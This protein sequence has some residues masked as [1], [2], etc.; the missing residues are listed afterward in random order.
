MLKHFVNEW[1]A[2]RENATILEEAKNSVGLIV[3][4]KSE[5]DFLGTKIH[6]ITNLIPGTDEDYVNE[7][8]IPSTL[9]LIQ[10]FRN[11]EFPVS[12]FIITL[13]QA[14]DPASASLEKEARQQRESHITDFIESKKEE[15]T[16]ILNCGAFDSAEIDYI[17]NYAYEQISHERLE[18][19]DLFIQTLVKY[20]EQ[21]FDAT[22]CLTKQNGEEV[23]KYDI[24]YDMICRCC[25]RR[26][27]AEESKFRVSGWGIKIA[28][29]DNTGDD[30]VPEFVKTAKEVLRAIYFDCQGY[31]GI[32]ADV[33]RNLADYYAHFTSDPIPYRIAKVQER[34]NNTRGHRRGSS[35]SASAMIGDVA[36]AFATAKPI[37]KKKSK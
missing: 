37:K 18:N 9:N 3:H 23:K 22:V 10:E 13:M 30:R 16:E 21:L 4:Q 2:A 12:E 32:F 14:V 36:A 11:S 33:V 5:I 26:I 8:F 28:F 29:L 25:N 27:M 6:L 31:I 7:F 17:V 19:I 35:V 1:A 15:W 34:L 20:P 24:I